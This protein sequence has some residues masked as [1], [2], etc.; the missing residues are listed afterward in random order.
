MSDDV[1]FDKDMSEVAKSHQVSQFSEAL[2]E[3]DDLSEDDEVISEFLQ[4]LESADQAKKVSAVKRY[5]QD[6]DID[7]FDEREES[8]ASSD[9]FDELF[10]EGDT[11]ESSEEEAK[12]SILKAIRNN[13]IKGTEKQDD[14]E[15]EFDMDGIDLP[16]K[17]QKIQPQNEFDAAS[18]THSIYPPAKSYTALVISGASLF[19]VVSLAVYSFLLSRHIDALKVSYD[20]IQPL[21]EPDNETHRQDIVIIE[22]RKQLDEVVQR[23]NQVENQKSSS[24]HDVS[25]AEDIKKLSRSV[26]TL[27]Q[28]MMKLEGN[29]EKLEKQPVVEVKQP[30]VAAKQ[31]VV[32]VAPPVRSKPRQKS[33]TKAPSKWAKKNPW[34]VNIVSYRSRKVADNAL[35]DLRSRGIDVEKTKVMVKGLDW[36]RLRVVGFAT[37]GSAQR[38]VIRLKKLPDVNGPW[39]TKR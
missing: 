21:A 16:M 5:E 24:E 8:D 7:D 38:Y 28:D 27:M 14:F 22:V 19:L 2:D 30:S 12:N 17:E 29:I 37:K 35:K 9:L 25:Q 10:D 4:G 11:Y 39:I 34:I 23:L 13:P 31:P 6:D 32:E 1:K 26:V 3:L 33:T 18:I 36:Y 15:S 20:N